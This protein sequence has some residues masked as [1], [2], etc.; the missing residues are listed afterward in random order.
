MK[1]QS[2]RRHAGSRVHRRARRGNHK[3]DTD[4]GGIARFLLVVD[5]SDLM[6]TRRV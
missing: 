2:Q 6:S 1:R 4:S 3:S 5:V